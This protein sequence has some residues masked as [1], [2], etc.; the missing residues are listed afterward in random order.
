MHNHEYKVNIIKQNPM[1]RIMRS[2]LD[3]FNENVSF[4][5][6]SQVSFP[7]G[8]LLK[9]TLGPDMQEY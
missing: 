5:E 1:R 7:K 9:L 2:V 3:L 6:A 8:S 4:F